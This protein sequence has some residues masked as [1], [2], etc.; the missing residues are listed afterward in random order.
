MKT[1]VHFK[2]AAFNSTE[3]RDYFINPSC[4][5]DDVCWWLIKELRARGIETSEAP[6]QEDFGW[7]VTF[8]VDGAEHN[9]VIGFQLG[10]YFVLEGQSLGREGQWLGWLERTGVVRGL[11]GRR[12]RDVQAAAVEAVNAALLSVPDVR[13]LEWVE[14]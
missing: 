14:R 8:K 12:Q 9:F 2:S 7:F 3:P 11:L 5:G 10:G 4:F 1:E 6:D 13:D